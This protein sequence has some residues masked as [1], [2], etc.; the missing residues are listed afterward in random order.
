MIQ[1]ENVR[2]LILAG[3]LGSRL[4]DLSKNCPKPLQPVNGRPFLEY[5]IESLEKQ[6]ITKI[7]LLTS[8]LSEF[9]EEHF[10]K[11]QGKAKIDV[12]VEKEPLGTGGAIAQAVLQLSIEEPFLVFN[13]DSFCLFDIKSL[14]KHADDYHAVISALTVSEGARFGGL[15]VNNNGILL[16]FSEKVPGSKLVNAGVYLFHPESFKGLTGVFSLEKEIFPKWLNNNN[17]IKVITLDS[18][19]LDIG[20]PES[21]KSAEYELQLLMSEVKK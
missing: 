16:E 20:T 9:I 5:L 6:G 15:K 13:G 14:I 1:I 8:Y 11:W 10:N 19:L 12:L 21:L 3:G 7:T 18:Q 2:V 17:K 4:G